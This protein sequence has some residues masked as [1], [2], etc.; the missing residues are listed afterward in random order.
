MAMVR[1]LTG[2][3]Q[4]VLGYIVEHLERHGY[5]PTLKEIAGHFGISSPNAVRDHLRALEGKGFLRRDADKSRALTVVGR[6]RRPARRGL[7]LLGEVAAGSPLLAEQ[8]F[9][10][11]VD[12]GGYFGDDPGTFVLRVKGD[13]MIGAG[14]NDGDLVVVR[15][16]ETLASGEIGVVILGQEAT[17]KRVFVEGRR[18]RLQPENDRLVPM[19]VSR[20]DPE[21]RIGGKVI[22][23]IRKF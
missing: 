12:L 14:I 15:H 10:D 19:L 6:E 9:Q 13:S 20:N 3:Q 22:G 7:P 8:N 5:P 1:E 18:L 11:A 23:V 2:K 16:Q 17:V 21:I 4:R